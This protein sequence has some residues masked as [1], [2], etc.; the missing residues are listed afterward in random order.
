MRKA[1]SVL[2]QKALSYLDLRTLLIGQAVHSR[3]L[4]A[5]CTEINNQLSTVVI[6]VVDNEFKAALA[7]STLRSKSARVAL[8]SN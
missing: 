6:N 7:S 5:C 8:M 2:H 1:P 4:I 3:Y